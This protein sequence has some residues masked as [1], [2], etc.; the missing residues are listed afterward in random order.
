VL[1]LSLK[2]NI[3]VARFYIKKG[4][5]APPLRVFLRQ[6]DG[7]P[8]PLATATV[9]FHMGN[10]KVASGTVNILDADLGKVEYRWQTGDT[11]TAG[12]FDGEF[13]ITDGGKNQTVPSNEYIVIKILDDQRT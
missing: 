4:D 10:G 5:T 7:S 9:V 1:L 8:I 2:G 12:S 11:D 13:E 3:D 6:R